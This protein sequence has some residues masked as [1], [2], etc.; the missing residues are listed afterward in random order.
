[1]PP[2]ESQRSIAFAAKS[3]KKKDVSTVKTMEKLLIH[4]RARRGPPRPGAAHGIEDSAAQADQIPTA[5][6]HVA[7]LQ[8]GIRLA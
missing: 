5:K 8:D 3:G 1:M 7:G 4:R 2:I 6:P